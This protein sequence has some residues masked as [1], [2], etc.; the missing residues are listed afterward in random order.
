M[1]KLLSLTQPKIDGTDRTLLDSFIN[2][3]ELVAN[4]RCPAFSTPL[5]SD[6]QPVS[7]AITAP[8]PNPIPQSLPPTLD[9]PDDLDRLANL[10][11]LDHDGQK[12]LHGAWRRLQK[13]YRDNEVATDDGPRGVREL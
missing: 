5:A 12:A 7:A 10:L 1:L 4:K 6:R 11:R 9:D 13:G 2:H 8:P 3:V